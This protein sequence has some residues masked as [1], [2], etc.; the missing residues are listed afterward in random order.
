MKKTIWGISLAAILVIVVYGIFGVIGLVPLP[1]AITRMFGNSD[2]EL[3]DM[4]RIPQIIQE[5]Y[6]TDVILLGEEIA[7]EANLPVR[8]I[9]E[10]TES[11]LNSGEAYQYT[12]FIVNDLNSEI[13]LTKD[14]VDL[15]AKKISQPNFCLAYLGSQYSTAW[16]DP[17]QYIANLDGNLF[18]RYFISGE[19]PRRCVG[20]WTQDDQAALEQYPYMLGNSMLYEIEAYLLEVN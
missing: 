18:C 10:V 11:S 20:A 16:D 3:T 14:E 6:P 7:F 13:Q 5:E 15:I 19:Q 8:T 9:T 12:F 17:G 1:K 4:E 2:D